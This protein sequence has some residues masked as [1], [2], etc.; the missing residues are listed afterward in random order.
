MSVTES[1][2]TDTNIVD[3]RQWRSVQRVKVLEAEGIKRTDDEH[4]ENLALLRLLFLQFLDEGNQVLLNRI[5]GVLGNVIPDEASGDAVASI[6]YSLKDLVIKAKAGRS[7]RLFSSHRGG[8]FFGCAH[9]VSSS[10]F[11]IVA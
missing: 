1:Y 9:G 10:K 3:I 2:K 11:G 4:A 7:R 5:Q 6:P 8:E